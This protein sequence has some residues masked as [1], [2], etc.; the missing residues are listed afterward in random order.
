MGV[1]RYSFDGQNVWGQIKK[2]DPEAFNFLYDKYIDALFSFG[3]T[4]S[5]DPDLVKDSIHDL[6]LELYK[7]RKK[8]SDTDNVKNYLFKSLKR[9][10]FVN[11]KRRLKVTYQ[12]ELLDSPNFKK[13]SFEKT[14]IEAEQREEV[15]S[16]LKKAIH[17]LSDR[18]RQAINLKYNAEFSYTE[19]AELLEISVESSRT[20]IYRALKSLKVSLSDTLENKSIILFLLK[21]TF[22]TRQ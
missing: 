4:F 19:I 14:I 13:E 12:Q 8:L 21:L 22:E 17:E 3:L 6:F 5:K 1:E 20:L 10:I 9:K 15:S 2:G 16:A 7:Y 18:Q 11:Q